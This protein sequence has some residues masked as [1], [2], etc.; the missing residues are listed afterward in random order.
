MKGNGLLYIV[1]GATGAVGGFLSRALGGW[2]NDII[3]LLIFMSIDMIT[4]ILIALFWHKSDKSKNGCLE[5]GACFRGLV[6]KCAMLFFVMIAVRL[7]MLIGTDYIRTAVIIGFITNEAISVIE[8]AA[9]MGLP[10]PE[11]LLKAIDILKNTNRGEV[12]R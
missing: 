11:V 12:E 5:S 3:T 1:C 4:G 9:V 6:R 8:N 7:D 10:L 2:T